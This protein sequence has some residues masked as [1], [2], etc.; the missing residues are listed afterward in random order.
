MIRKK[1][2]RNQAEQHRI[3]LEWIAHKF[4]REPETSEI[5]DSI[6]RLKCHILCVARAP[7]IRVRAGSQ[8]RRYQQ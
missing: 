2:P 4:L 1:S 3:R 6:E 7:Q 5:A 8:D